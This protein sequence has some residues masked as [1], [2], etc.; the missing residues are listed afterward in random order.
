M[1]VALVLLGVVRSS[2]LAQDTGPMLKVDLVVPAGIAPDRGGSDL[3]VYLPTEASIVTI[4]RTPLIAE[5]GNSRPIFMSIRPY[6]STASPI[7]ERMSIT[8]DASLTLPELGAETCFTF[9]NQV[10]AFEA[11]GVAQSYKYFAVV[12]HLEVH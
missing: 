2:A 5:A 1:C 12:V 11:Q 9:E 4:S 6:V 8:A 10:G 3:C 7:I